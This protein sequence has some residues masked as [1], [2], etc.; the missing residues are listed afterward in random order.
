M[1]R[2][3]QIRDAQGCVHDLVV[4]GGGITGVGVARD[5]ALRGLKVVLLERGD[6]ACGTSSRSSKLIHGGLRYLEHLHLGLVRESV[7]ERWRLMQAAPHLVRPLPFLF[8]GYKGEKPA[9]AVVKAGTLAYSILSSFRAP[10]PRAG[11]GPAETTERLPLLD[12]HG[13][14]GAAQY[15]DCSTDDSRLTLEA[16]LDACEAGAR[17]FTRANVVSVARQRSTL[18]FEAEDLTLGPPATRLNIEAR[19]AVIAAGPWTDK[20]LSCCCPGTV[21]WL[22]PTKGVHLVVPTE[23]LP[24]SCAVV[25]KSV[26]GDRRNTFAVPWGSFSYIGTTDTDFPNPDVEPDVTAADADYM[27]AIANRY[28]PRAALTRDDIV[29]V[30]AGVR[31][32]VAPHDEVD[33]TTAPDPS[34]VSREEKIEVFD[35]AFVVVAGGKL[36]TW[37]L[38]AERATDAACKLLERKHSVRSS[39][40]ATAT[41]QLP[42]AAGFTGEQDLANRLRLEFPRLPADWLE[43]LART[44]GTRA[45]RIARLASAERSLLEPLPVSGPYRMAELHYCILNE[46]VCSPEDFLVRRT[47]I[48]FVAS[49][50]GRA[51]VPVVQAALLSHQVASPERISASCTGYLSR[52]D[53]WRKSLAQNSR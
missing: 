24:L 23:R 45:A 2:D 6:I 42:G 32:L 26:A 37:R 16:A 1:V 52:L 47:P 35:D 12:S 21:P 44:F 11:L 39:R 31:P 34:D 14:R 20:V 50:Q 46:H 9:L 5:A 22:R 53:S 40:C 7:T 38:M 10:G 29:S 19:A 13:L 30:W 43:H 15:Y 33:P 8:P 4:V 17:L 49:D 27:L 18:V 36:T 25:M 48:H 3:E 28:F 51:A 41:R